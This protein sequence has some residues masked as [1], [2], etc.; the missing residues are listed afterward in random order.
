M[1]YILQ[2]EKICKYLEFNLEA[3]DMR[4]IK[5]NI[6]KTFCNDT[7]LFGCFI[8]DILN[9]ENSGKITEDE[10]VYN[11]FVLCF[12]NHKT[13]KTEISF[14][15][16]IIRYSKYYITLVFEETDNRVLLNTIASVNS[17]YAIEYYP[18]LMELIDNF[19]IGKIDSISFALMLQSITD[20]VFRNF[21]SEK[22]TEV[23]LEN[24]RYKLKTIIQSRSSERYAV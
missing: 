18:F 14:I 7:N 16:K 6:K 15:E 24:L 9:H 10:E 8:K 12:E 11:D 2:T 22:P 4:K 3:Q 19:T 13:N 1:D 20:D 5:S 17:C 21:E 23:H